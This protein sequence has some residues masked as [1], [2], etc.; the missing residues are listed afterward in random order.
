MKFKRFAALAVCGALALTGCGNKKTDGTDSKEKVALPETAVMT[1]GDIEASN[2][3]F[4]FFANSYYTQMGDADASKK[5]A[6]EEAE[7]GYLRVAV[8][9][10]MGIE[11]DDAAK[12]DMENQ[13]AQIKSSYGDGYQ[14]FL[15]ENCLSEEDIDTIISFGYYS[16]ALQATLG[17]T[18]YTD[19]QKRDYFKNHY[20]RA[21]H[22]LVMID[23]D[24]DDEAAKAKAEEVLEKAK[25]GEDFDA[26]IA[27]YGEDPGMEANPDGY[28][29]TDGTMVQEFQDGVDSLKPGE[30]TM[31]KTTYGYHVI[32][33]LDLEETPEYFE[34]QYEQYAEDLTDVM[35]DGMFENQLKK[36]AEEYNIKVVTNDDIVDEI[37]SKV[38]E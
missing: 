35:A 7:S 25:A 21:K 20:R 37:I 38:T 5:G 9:K 14:P 28:V 36:W 32:E 19:E 23:D 31:V 16:D 27:E 8:A 12:S 33:R 29:F 34:E 13:K 24:T 2:G 30:F 22:V 15:D 17:D 10:A 26:L 18:E 3:I 11:L 1:V 4:Y 6:L